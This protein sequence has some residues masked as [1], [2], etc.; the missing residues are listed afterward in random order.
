MDLRGRLQKYIRVLL[1]A[2]KPTKD[3][4]INASKVTAAGMAVIGA[5]GFAIFLAFIFAGI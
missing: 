1:V 5:V 2:R 4:F 3:E